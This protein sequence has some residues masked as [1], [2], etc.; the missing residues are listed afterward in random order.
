MN[1]ATSALPSLVIA[2]P[3]SARDQLAARVRAWQAQGQRVG[4]AS[5]AFDLLHAGHLDFLSRLRERVDRLVVAVTSDATVRRRGP[6]RPVIPETQR[7]ALVGAL[8][9]VDAAFLFSEYGDAANLE[10]LRPDVFGRGVD[11]SAQMFETPTLERLGTEVTIIATPRI[12]SATEIAE[13]LSGYMRRISGREFTGP[14]V[15]AMFDQDGTLSTAR[16]GWEIVMRDMML[17]QIAPDTAVLCPQ[18]KRDEIRR[19]VD[20]FISATTGIQTLKQMQGLAEMV[21][22]HGLRPPA[23]IFDARHYKEIYN[24]ALKAHV[25]GRFEPIERG[26]LEAA[27]LVIKNSDIFVGRLRDA[28]VRLYLASGTDEA[29]VIDEAKRLDY[30]HHFADRVLGARGD[31]EIN[32]KAVMLERVRAELP[33]GATMANVVVFG[34]GPCEMREARNAGAY[35]IGIASDDARRHGWNHGKTQRLIDAGA[36]IIIPDFSR[37]AELMALLRI[38]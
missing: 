3:N 17:E 20:A 29:D 33:A 11:H 14:L 28:G 16:Y 13:R 37:M 1:S 30:G 31:P 23:E 8:R 21:R 5:G 27:D 6:D 36:D 24:R 35:A 2:E 32:V 19:E 9:C 25:N 10:S 34:D 18:A 38:A 4:L 12:T 15:S 26:W 7:V 22:R